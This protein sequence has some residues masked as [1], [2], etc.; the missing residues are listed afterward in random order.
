MGTVNH[1]QMRV[2]ILVLVTAIDVLHMRF[3]QLLLLME[4]FVRNRFCFQ[5][6]PQLKKL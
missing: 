4:I 6:G 5:I 2:M 3:L 1:D